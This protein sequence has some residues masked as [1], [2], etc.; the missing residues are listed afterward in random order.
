MDKIKYSIVTPAYNEQESLP[1]FFTKV[2]P[3][4]ETLG[5]PF[6]IIAVND[7]SRDGTENI[8]AEYAKKDKRIKA[9]NFSR[10]FGQQAALL[11]GLKHSGGQ[12]VI[13][14]DAD[15]QDSPDIIGKL[16]V[17]WKAGYD[18][19]HAKRAKRKGE[20]AFK[21]FTAF[22]YYR[23][24]R[25][26]SGMDIPKDT[27]DF[28]LY[29]RKVVDTIISL[30]EHNRLLRAQ[31]TWVG[32]RQTS[33]EFERPERQVGQTKYTLKKM[34]K[35]ATDGIIPNSSA[36]LGLTA[37]LGVFLNIS[38]LI[39]Y[40]VFIVFA[41]IGKALPLV[42]WIFP[43]AAILTSF[44][45]ITNGLTNM[46]IGSIYEEVKNRPIYIEKNNYNL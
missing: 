43:T 20:S 17:K 25:K 11:C 29:D 7:G 22:C 36:I 32:F 42:A 1:L 23:L 3:I 31:T 12:A 40:I 4:M 5:E 44:I 34:I 6:E 37:K 28:K 18:V 35:L 24:L 46:Y 14:M 2:I 39:C 10:N 8:L 13:C 38:S 16:I 19:V 30:S 41:C 45:L 9:V 15:L 21:K 26:L 27:G 33:I